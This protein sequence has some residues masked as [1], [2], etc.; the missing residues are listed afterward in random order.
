MRKKSLTSMVLIVSVI[1]LLVGCGQA[2]KEVE[3]DYGS[4]SIYAKEDMD[5]AIALIK[6]EFQNFKGCVLHSLSYSG[7]EECNAEH[8]AWMRDLGKKDYDESIAFMMKFQSPK[9]GGGNWS[10]DEEYKWSWHLARLKG[11]DW[12][13]L[14]WGF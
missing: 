4:S 11:G 1:L 12:E 9:E 14:T 2:K 3:I 5:A 10:P 7:D 13:L 6:E 8:L